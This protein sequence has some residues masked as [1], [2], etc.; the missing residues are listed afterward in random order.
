MNISKQ[1]GWSNEEN[2]IY[3]ISSSIE[4]INSI[5]SGN[6]PNYVIPISKQT[7]WSNKNK[8]LYEWLRQLTKLTA[9]IDNCC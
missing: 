8:L 5:Y 2:I 7:G 4:K 3:N 6:Q 1:I 9:H